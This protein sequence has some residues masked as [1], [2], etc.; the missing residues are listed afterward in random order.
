M[1]TILSLSLNS[2]QIIKIPPHETVEISSY[3][4]KFYILSN[5]NLNQTKYNIKNR[6]TSTDINPQANNY[7]AFSDVN[8]SIIN[9][10]DELEIIKGWNLEKGTCNAESYFLNYSNN[11]NMQIYAKQAC[12]FS[13]LTFNSSGIKFSKTILPT[14]NIYTPLSEKPIQLEYYYTGL[15]FVVQIHDHITN[16]LGIAFETIGINENISNKCGLTS[17]I[18]NSHNNTVDDSLFKCNCNKF[19]RPPFSIALFALLYFAVIGFI[20]F[21]LEKGNIISIRSYF[22]A[23]IANSQPATFANQDTEPILND[24]EYDV[25]NVDA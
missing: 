16:D 6:T 21:L 1:N 15:P 2:F 8:I 25:V 12:L 19:T 5:S 20:I 13:P 3:N 22:S 18:F 24:I 10:G 17:F 4:S 9:Y 23:N 14:H 11:M 7:Y